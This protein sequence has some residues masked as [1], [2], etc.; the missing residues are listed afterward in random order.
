MCN[1][2]ILSFSNTEIVPITAVRIGRSIITIVNS[3][4]EEV[5]IMQKLSSFQG[6]EE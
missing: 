3:K 4:D 1:K 5:E 2:L 6:N